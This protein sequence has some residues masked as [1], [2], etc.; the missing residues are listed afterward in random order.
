MYHLN[1]CCKVVYH[2]CSSSGT[3][4]C[5]LLPILCFRMKA[6]TN[7]FVRNA[8]VDVSVI[9]SAKKKY[10]NVVTYKSNLYF[11]TI[12]RMILT[13]LVEVTQYLL[14]RDY[15]RVRHININL[16]SRKTIVRTIF[17][18]SIG[19]S[20][21]EIG[22]GWNKSSV[23]GRSFQFL[24]MYFFW[25]GYSCLVRI[26]KQ[27]VCSIMCISYF[28]SIYMYKYIYICKDIYI[29][30]YIYIFYHISQV[31]TILESAKN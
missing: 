6:V 9:C 20:H 12:D 18:W 19:W 26:S 27:I 22:K 7:K 30:I 16:Q 17:F 21:F 29:Y 1:S 25:L 8:F 3:K 15:L 24:S 4:N 28:N 23:K 14:S 31:K 13:S 11:Q 5:I 10:D 2:Q